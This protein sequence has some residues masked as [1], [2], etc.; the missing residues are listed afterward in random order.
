MYGVPGAGAVNHTLNPRLFDD[1]L[2]YIIN[3]AEDRWIFVDPDIAPIIGRLRDR[4]PTVEGVVVMTDAAHMPTGEAAVGLDGALCYE[5]WLAAQPEDQGWTQVDERDACGICYTS[6]TTGDP[7]GVVY[8]HRS[9]VLHAMAVLQKD[10]LNYGAADMV[11]PVVPLFHANGW[12]NGY[13]APMAGAGMVMP[14]RD[15]TPPALYEMLEK[16]V[17]ITLAVPTVWLGLLRYLEETGKRFSTLERV[18]IG[19]SACPQAVMEKFEDVYGVEVIHAWGMTETS[20]LGAVRDIDAGTQIAEPRR[21]DRRQV[22]DRAAVLHC[23]SEGRTRRRRRRC[24]AGDRRRGALGWR[25]PG[26]PLYPRPRRGGAV[27]RPRRLDPRR[28]GWFDTGDVG[29]MDAQGFVRITDRSKDVIKSGGEW[30]SSIDLEN[31]AVGHPAVAEAAAIGVAHPKWDE[32]PVLVVVAA[33]GAT[34]DK[35]SVI[36]HVAERVAKWQVP[37][38]VV[39]VEEIPHTATGK[40]SKLALREQLRAMGYAHPDL[41][42]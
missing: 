7:K 17:T 33:A 34:P 26:T 15:L 27:S 18:V 25:H 31:I 40:I 24:R 13:S 30:I 38:D 11:M 29:T 2:I 12:S 6:G 4:L 41:A 37:D 16:G 39:V 20:P 32:R 3:H 9:N 5:D 23:R 8:S 22:E 21:A 28:R 10:V 36:A 19:G 42:P 35:A 14:G 1:Q